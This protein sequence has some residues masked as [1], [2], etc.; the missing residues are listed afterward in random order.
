[1]KNPLLALVFVCSSALAQTF[2]APLCTGSSPQHCTW[3]ATLPTTAIDLSASQFTEISVPYSTFVPSG[4]SGVIS[5]D[6]VNVMVE[7]I[8]QAGKGISVLVIESP[9]NSGVWKRLAFLYDGDPAGQ[10]SETF[11][12]GVTMSSADEVCVQIATQAYPAAGQSPFFGASSWN[13]QVVVTIN[14]TVP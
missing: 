2:P 10:R 5:I 13:R 3:W 11:P 12:G 8:A 1:M 6:S 4:Y 7:G 14:Y 9:A